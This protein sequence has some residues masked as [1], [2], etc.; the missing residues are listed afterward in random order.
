MAVLGL[1]CCAGAFS[2]CSKRG[3]LSVAAHMLLFV[4]A[5][6]IP[7]RGLSACLLAS[8]VAAPPLA[9]DVLAH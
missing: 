8:V 5:S 7:E 6:L 4:M 2:S 9:Q 3:L 1:R